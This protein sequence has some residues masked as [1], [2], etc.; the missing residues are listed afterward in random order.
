M[1]EEEPN[2][3]RDVWGGPEIPSRVRV[4][5]ASGLDP[6]LVAMDKVIAALNLIDKEAKGRVLRWYC[7]R[8]LDIR[9]DKIDRPGSASN[10]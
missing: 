3:A 4:V 5:Y 7:E 9:W 8:F 6:E 2:I 1:P 10:S